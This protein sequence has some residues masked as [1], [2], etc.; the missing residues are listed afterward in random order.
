MVEALLDAIQQVFE[1]FGTNCVVVVDDSFNLKAF[2]TGKEA[3]INKAFKVVEFEGTKLEDASIKR[4]NKQQVVIQIR[5]VVANASIKAIDNDGF[6][7]C[8]V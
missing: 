5:I 4:I 3:L 7:C 8:Q 2:N 1:F 6:F